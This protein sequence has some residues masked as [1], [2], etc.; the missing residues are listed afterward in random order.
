MTL[1]VKIGLTSLLLGVCSILLVMGSGFGPCG[2]STSLG[3]VIL[4][5]GCFA[6]VAG[7]IMM[8]CVAIRAIFVTGQ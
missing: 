8:I 6:F 1:L 4:I 2:P 5:L 3:S 7:S